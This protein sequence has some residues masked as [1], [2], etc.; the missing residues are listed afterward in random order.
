MSGSG[1]VQPAD[2]RVF[3]SNL[4]EYVEPYFTRLLQRGEAEALQGY[5]PYGGQ[6][7]SYFSPDELT[8]QAMGRGFGMAGT[9]QQYTDA[10]RRYGAQ[11]TIGS[12]FTQGDV[13]SGYAG[14]TIE[15]GYRAGEL[16]PQQYEKNIKRFMSPYQQNVIDIEKRE[17]KRQSDMAAAQ[18]QDSAAKSGGLGGFREAIM[19]AERQ[20]NLGQQMGD[21]QM[22][23]SQAGFQS[24]QEQ[25][26]RERQYGL[27]R[28]GAQEQARQSEEKFNQA[29]FAQSQQAMQQAARL[30][31][32]AEQ[33]EQAGRQAQEKF[34]QNAFD[35][36]SR[37]NLAAAR[38]L[39]ESGK[40]IQQD[41]ISRMQILEGIG[42]QQRALEQASLDMGYQDFVNQR[43]FT[44][45]QLNYLS[46][47]L[48][49][50]PVQANQVQST[51]QQQPGL[52]QTVFGGGLSALGFLRGAGQV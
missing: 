13:R 26:A 1:S 52:F 8:A 25:L 33:I 36:S 2:Q 38:G 15:S 32:T 35:L 24:A 11:G 10:S 6:R 34:R 14:D 30:G 42:K 18:M 22:R 44:R 7:L 47:L 9:P 51:Y 17:A 19:Q 21:I 27:Q 37:Y 20:R 43:D 28:Y 46:Q 3:S 50:V 23:G 41:A 40:G 5:Q 4:P 12:Q 45:N 39:M 31:L 49:G 48:Q 16:T 29:A